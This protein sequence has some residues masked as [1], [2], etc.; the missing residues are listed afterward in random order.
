MQ[1]ESE[2]EARR[3]DDLSA[4]LLFASEPTED[5]QARI[6]ELEAQLAN[7]RKEV[8]A[9]DRRRAAA[10]V[11][12]GDEVRLTATSPVLGGRKKH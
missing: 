1:L 3:A 10:T 9:Q 12:R 2:A 7:A 6:Q 4:K 8:A 5:L 11:V